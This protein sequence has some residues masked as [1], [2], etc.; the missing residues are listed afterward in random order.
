[1]HLRSLRRWWRER[2]ALIKCLR[3]DRG[4]EYNSSEFKE[5][6]DGY[7]IQRQLTSAYTPQQNGIAKRKNRSILNMV[8]SVLSG[9]KVPKIFWPEE[10]M[11]CVH[12]LDRSPAAAV[13][14]MTLEEAWSRTRPLVSNFR[15][16]GRLAHTH[17]PKEKRKNL[18][19][20]SIKCVVLD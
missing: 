15:L 13:E 4:G 20:K 14:G 6:C 11:W 1:M 17:I 19:D 5:L 12:V 10:T 3:S 7:G 9:K 16:F 2:H 18:D 8:R